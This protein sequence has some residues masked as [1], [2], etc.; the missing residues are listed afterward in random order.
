MPSAASSSA[1]P[2]GPGPFEVSQLQ[3]W[4][5]PSCTIDEPPAPVLPAPVAELPA[6]PVVPPVLVRPPVP[7]LPPVPVVE[8][9]PSGGGTTMPPSGSA[10]WPSAHLCAA[11]HWTP[12]QPSL[13]SP[14]T[15][16]IGALQVTL[17]HP[18]SMQVPAVGSGAAL[19]E[20]TFPLGQ[21]RQPQAARQAPPSQTW[22][23][24]HLIPLQGS[25]QF[26]IWQT[27]PGGQTTP[28][29]PPTQTPRS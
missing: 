15:Q 21:F 10:H 11:G 2:L 29:Q 4:M 24:P 16:T 17:S 27:W 20:Q 5:P 6:A 25:T 9:P 23:S 22:P 12:A 13:H 28:S 1:R 3:V 18:L 7:V 14:C 26:P 19:S 8:T